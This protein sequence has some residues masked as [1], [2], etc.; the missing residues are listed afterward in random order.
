MSAEATVT[1]PSPAQRCLLI[2]FVG[3]LGGWLGAFLAI[4]L[5]TRVLPQLPAIT[6]AQVPRLM[7]FSWWA[8]FFYNFLFVA[9]M[10]A[11]IQ[12]IGRWQT[13][14]L[15]EQYRRRL[16]QSGLLA[17]IRDGSADFGLAGRVIARQPWLIRSNF[18]N[19][20][21]PVGDPHRDFGHIGLF[22]DLHLEGGRNH[23]L[24]LRAAP[25]FMFAPG[26]A[27]F[28]GF[29]SHYGVSL[30]PAELNIFNGGWLL[31][32]V[33]SVLLTVDQ[34]IALGYAWHRMLLDELG[35]EFRDEV[36]RRAEAEAALEEKR[37]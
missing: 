18:R 25:V 35:P 5:G 9:L 11:A 33:V 22:L 26:I 12:G 34:V 15:V 24:F 30:L 36:R 13:R 27:G 19:Y 16:R 6:A 37:A 1:G 32:S 23:K 31:C 21:A 20:P 10:Y 28:L 29:L 3:L 8:G 17:R 4:E 2:V 14:R 7:E